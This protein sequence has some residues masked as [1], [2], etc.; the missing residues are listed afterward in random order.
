MQSNKCQPTKTTFEL[1]H[2]KEELEDECNRSTV[3]NQKEHQDKKSSTSA[4]EKKRRLRSIVL[5][6][7]SEDEGNEK[8]QS[9]TVEKAVPRNK[10]GVQGKTKNTKL[11]DEGL[12]VGYTKVKTSV[13]AATRM[14]RSLAKKSNVSYKNKLV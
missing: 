11:E 3:I 4:N 9:K 8:S 12:D 10:R 7:D 2:V 1:V 6:G 13:S 14:T 5:S